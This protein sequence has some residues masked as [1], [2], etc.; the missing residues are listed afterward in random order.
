M[1][2]I[3]SLTSDPAPLCLD[4]AHS[5]PLEDVGGIWGHEHLIEVLSA[6]DHPERDD[7]LGWV[8]ED[9][10]PEHFSCDEVNMK[11]QRLKGKLIPKALNKRTEHIKP[12]KLTKSALNKHLKQLDNGQLIDLVKAC[13]SASKDMERFLAVKILGDEAVEA[14]FQEYRKKVEQ[15]F[16]PER[17][18][19]KLR[20]QDAQRA[21]SEFKRLTGSL[22]Y[23]TELKLIYVEN[24]V[25]FTLT[26]GDIDER[27]YNSIVS[28][29][30]DI[31]DQVNEDETGELFDE[32]EE[33]LAAVVANTDGIGW[34]FMKI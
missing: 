16:F 30:A 13:Y 32:F 20:L 33:R 4:G 9:Y 19:G 3:D 29:Y 2:E 7:F 21:I 1:I 11:L 18:L 6:P 5:C 8:R 31:V 15:E 12:V 24:G 22:L 26:Y 34:G 17:G 27:F 10:D 23:S 14:L 28:M 25:D